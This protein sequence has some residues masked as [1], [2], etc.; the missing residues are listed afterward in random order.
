M[1]YLTNKVESAA[2]ASGALWTSRRIDD[3]Q[4]AFI[5]FEAMKG[6][7]YVIVWHVVDTAIF[8]ST[9]YQVEHV[10]DGET[11]DLLTVE[12]MLSNSLPVVLSMIDVVDDVISPAETHRFLDD[13]RRS[14][15]VVVAGGCCPKSEG[16]VPQHAA[17]R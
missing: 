4:D 6:L 11:V 12:V 16:G 9:L 15:T 3:S 17:L 14:S 8:D 7:E 5:I 2:L 13:A 1:S 10:Y